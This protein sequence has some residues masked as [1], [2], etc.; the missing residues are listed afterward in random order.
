MTSTGESEMQSVEPVTT[1]TNEEFL[2]M[3]R[4]ASEEIKALR[5]H[6]SFLL[7]KAQAYDNM[8]LVLGMIPQQRQGMSEDFASVLDHRIKFLE[9]VPRPADEPAEAPAG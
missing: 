2:N 8:A 6:I 4:R 3:A 7:P 5:A 1:V 9:N